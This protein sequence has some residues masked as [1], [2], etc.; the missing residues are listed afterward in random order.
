MSE[1][2]L[3]KRVSRGKRAKLLM[4]DE[5]L[6]EAFDALKAAYSKALMESHPLAKDE[7]EK[8]YLAFNVVGKVKE[9]LASIA[10][11]GSLADHELA[12]L[13]AAPQRE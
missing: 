6:I 2:K 10:A 1:D 8:Y 12:R 5:L 7:R 9:H 13:N 4:Q 3:N 11:D